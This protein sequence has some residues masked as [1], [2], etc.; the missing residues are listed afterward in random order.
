M[1]HLSNYLKLQGIRP[2]RT[3]V[4]TRE[5]RAKIWRRLFPGTTFVAATGSFGKTTATQLLARMLRTQGRTY[6]RTD[7]N[8]PHNIWDNLL[9]AK[10]WRIRYFVQEVSGH[11]P[12]SVSRCVAALRPSI[13]I[14]TAISGDHR[15]AFG[16][17]EAT[18]LEKSALVRSLPGSGLAVLNADDPLVAAMAAGSPCR[19]VRFGSN[20]DADLRLIG[21][22]SR[23]PERLTV[24]VEYKGERFEVKTQLVGEHWAV[25][26]M[27]ALLTALE[28]GVSRSDCLSALEDARPAYNRMSVHRTPQGGWC[29]L[30][31]YKS[32]YYGIEVCLQF[33]AQSSAPRKTVLFGTVSDY[34][35]S[36]KS[37]YYNVARMALAVADRVIFTGRNAERVRRLATGE[38]AGRLFTAERPADALRMI[39]E[40]AVPDEL[41]YVKATRVDKL[42]QLLAPRR[43][44]ISETSILRS[45]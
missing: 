23:W 5:F 6:F 19:V 25:S 4:R 9:R 7:F 40:N 28:M 3:W 36:S 1:S 30:D 45:S 24:E 8:E 17:S 41:I 21:A 26:V 33:L 10:P 31:A 38:F 27:A 15:K 12:G 11:K 18:A 22:R 2:P 13:G 42:A 35:G 14:V 34:T 29:V 44:S 32:S 39:E 16:G 43:E 37:H 20:A